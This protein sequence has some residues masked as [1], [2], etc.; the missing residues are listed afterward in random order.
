MMYE[1]SL[2]EIKKFT[3]HNQ[4]FFCKGIHEVQT[5]NDAL[6]KLKLE[7]EVKRLKELAD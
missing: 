5:Q 2:E 4:P 1:Q 6:N 7:N 3:N